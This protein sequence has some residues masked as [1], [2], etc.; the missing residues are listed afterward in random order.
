MEASQVSMRVLTQGVGDTWITH[1]S[2][3]NYPGNQ[4]L[5]LQSLIE[6]NKYTNITCIYKYGEN[7]CV[8]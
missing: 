8:K 1:S 2:S 7:V 5:F 4:M 6:V 3:D